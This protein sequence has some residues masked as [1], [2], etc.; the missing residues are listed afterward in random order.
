MWVDA[1]SAESVVLLWTLED[2]QAVKDRLI[3]TAASKEMVTMFMA[4]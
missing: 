3:G 1:E 4:C 2:W